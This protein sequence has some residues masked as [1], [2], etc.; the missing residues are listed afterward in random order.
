MEGAYVSVF[1]FV[2]WCDPR[3]GLPSQGMGELG[4]GG[5]RN[6]ALGS[7][8][9]DGLLHRK[10][11]ASRRLESNQTLFSYPTSRWYFAFP[12]PLALSLSRRRNAAQ[13]TLMLVGGSLGHRNGTRRARSRPG[14]E[15]THC[16]EREEPPVA[17]V[18]R[19]WRLG[20]TSRLHRETPETQ[21]FGEQASRFV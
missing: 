14:N 18:A 21:L 9:L 10:P 7:G 15:Y 3:L 19:E 20:R 8:D 17:S 5:V 13:L 16:P 12:L 6:T 1:V 11:R 2:C 4:H